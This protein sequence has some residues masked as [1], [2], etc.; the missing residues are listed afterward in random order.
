MRLYL[1]NTSF[2]IPLFWISRFWARSDG[3]ADQ[4]S[5][6][7][8]TVNIVWFPQ[9]LKKICILGQIFL[10]DIFCWRAEFVNRVMSS[11][12]SLVKLREVT[13][14]MTASLHW[15]FQVGGVWVGKQSSLR[16]DS[17][18][19]NQEKCSAHSSRICEVN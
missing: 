16:A 18:L 5:W 6:K 14:S 19:S 10:V 17:V 8:H 15:W 3:Q 4:R 1:R 2:I 12:I 13:Y 7:C 9:L 11:W